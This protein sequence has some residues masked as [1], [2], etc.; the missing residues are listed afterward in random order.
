MNAKVELA[1]WIPTET[2][3]HGATWRWLALNINGTPAERNRNGQTRLE[4]G[5]IVITTIR[6]PGAKTAEWFVSRVNE[7]EHMT[8]RKPMTPDQIITVCHY[9]ESDDNALEFISQA[10]LSMLWDPLFVDI[11]E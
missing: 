9:I 11:D 5:M 1:H 7:N 2:K 8:E 3:R 4:P 10:P 6:K